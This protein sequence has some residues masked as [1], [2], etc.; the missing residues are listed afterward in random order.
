LTDPAHGTVI[1]LGIITTT[2]IN[3]RPTFD[4]I[5]IS[6]ILLS[7]QTQIGEECLKVQ[8]SIEKRE[9]KYSK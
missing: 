2:L 8:R 7:L 6:N 3:T 9:K 4:S 1:S 5:V